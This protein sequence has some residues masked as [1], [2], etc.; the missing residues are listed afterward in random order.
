MSKFAILLVVL[1]LAIA[2]CGGTGNL[3]DGPPLSISP[4]SASLLPDGQAQ[5][6]LDQVQLVDWSAPDGGTVVNGLF[7]AP[8]S[9]GTYRV[10][11]TSFLNPLNTTT[12]TVTVATVAVSVSPF[13][14]MVAP[15]T[16]TNNAF[17]A[18]ISGSPNKA[19]TWTVDQVNGGSIGSSTADGSGNARANYTAGSTPGIFTIR[20]TASADSTVSDMGQ[21]HVLGPSSVGLN[22]RSV[23]LSTTVPNNAVLLT[24]VLTDASGQVDT[25]TALTWDIPLNPVGGVLSGS[26]PRQRTLTVPT[27]FSGVATCQ[28]RVRNAQG[29]A[30]MATIQVVSG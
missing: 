9:T 23:T 6:T 13:Q 24:A 22:P 14:I 4:G 18:V 8:G 20:A 26:D 21:V 1:A 2:G 5:F 19:V 12:A 11:A 7:T 30:A 3:S 29:V 17:T 27:S 15:G 25:T 16:T 28:V 10:V